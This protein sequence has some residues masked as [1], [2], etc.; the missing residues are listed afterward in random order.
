MSAAST[1][2][3]SCQSA[4]LNYIVSLFCL[5][6]HSTSTTRRHSST[7]AVLGLGGRLS[8]RSVRIVLSDAKQGSRGDEPVKYLGRLR[9]TNAH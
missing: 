6:K 5:L 4:E 2:A 3:L 1:A 8:P 9:G 7:P